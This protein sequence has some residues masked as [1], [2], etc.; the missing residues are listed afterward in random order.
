MKNKSKKALRGKF[1]LEELNWLDADYN[2]D[3]EYDHDE[4]YARDC[5]HRM[6]VSEFRNKYSYDEAY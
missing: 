3:D 2:C 4:Y 5:E 6:L 1:Y